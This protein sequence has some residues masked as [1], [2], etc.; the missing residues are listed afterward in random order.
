MRTT[1]ADRAMFTQGA[2][3]WLAIAIN[4][5]SG[6]PVCAFWRAEDYDIHAFVETPRGTYLDVE[7]EHSAEWFLDRWDALKIREVHNVSIFNGWD[8]MLFDPEVAKA[9]AR[10][11]AP[12]LI[13]KVNLT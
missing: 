5:M 6:W 1:D 3:H 12:G 7:G 8:D 4:E 10:K 11:L 9:R 2:C 13:A